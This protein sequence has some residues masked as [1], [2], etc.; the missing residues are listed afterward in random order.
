MQN[1]KNA[2]SIEVLLEIME[3]EEKKAYSNFE[4]S[5]QN[6][7]RAKFE[8]NKKHI[9]IYKK[10]MKQNSIKFSAISQAIF[11]IKTKGGIL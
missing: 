8:G 9:T 11:N 2:V 5:C 1:T 3:A 10:E 6:L 4:R 7:G